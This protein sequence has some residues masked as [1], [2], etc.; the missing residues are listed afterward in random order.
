MSLLHPQAVIANTE[1]TTGPIDVTDMVLVSIHMPSGFDGTQLAI[2]GCDT[3]DGTYLPVHDASG[4]ALEITIAASTIAAVA[5]DA[6][7]GL[8][9]I[10][11]ES[12]SAQS[13][14]ITLMLGVLPDDRA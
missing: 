5:P 4:V 13:P 14:A 12:D 2:L 9:Y 8:R 7:R 1:D 10:K 11:L 3:L 6:T